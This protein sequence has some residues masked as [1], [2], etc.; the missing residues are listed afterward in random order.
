MLGNIKIFRML[1]LHRDKSSRHGGLTPWRGI[2]RDRYSVMTFCRALLPTLLIAAGFL[3][4]WA[5]DSNSEDSKFQRNRLS[6]IR[7]MSIENLDGEK[8]GEVSDL[9]IVLPTGDVKYAVIK[10][11]RFAGLR[12][13]RRIVPAHLVSNATIKKNVLEM[14]LS[15][16]KLKSAPRYTKD[17]LNALRNPRRV[18]EIAKYYRTS[19]QPAAPTP[20]GA[21]VVPAAQVQKSRELLNQTDAVEYHL[22]QELIG[23]NV[24]DAENEQ[25]GEISDLLVDLA[26]E[27]PSVAII[28]TKGLFRIKSPLAAPLRALIG[29][30]RMRLNVNSAAVL[31][32]PLLTSKTW[33]SSRLDVKPVYIFPD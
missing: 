27:K 30:G 23:S 16:K 15:L 1:N 3:D 20:T 14:D 7:G 19:T 11:R 4:V 29:T 25:L 8:L 6:R 10:S 9:I 12:S 17:E 26:A 5:G 33:Q 32:A 18:R 31:K 28:S 22:A 24:Y 21:Q 13:T 2:S